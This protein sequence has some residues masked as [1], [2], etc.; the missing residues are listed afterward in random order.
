LSR[1]SI[2]V[3]Q[4][5]LPGTIIVV[6][7][8]FAVKHGYAGIIGSIGRIINYEESTRNY[9]CY[10]IR[11]SSEGLRNYWYIQIEDANEIDNQSLLSLLPD[12][13]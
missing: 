12:Y 7:E 10:K 1:R 5:L 4:R 3:E 13:E 8:K 9:D 11:A 2:P 6:G